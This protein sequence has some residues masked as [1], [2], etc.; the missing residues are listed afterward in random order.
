MA[1]EFE[2]RPVL[3]EETL[4]A[5]D[6]QRDGLYVDCTFGRGGHAARI[7]QALGP[8]GRLLALDKDPHA[9]AVAREQFANE[10]RF[11][12][13]QG[14]FTR[15]EFCVAEQGWLSS[16]DGVLLDLGVSSPQL[17]DA[18]RGFSFRR[19]GELDMRM[20]PSS[21]MSAAQWL[22]TV[23]EQELA[24]VFR[25]YGEE[26]YAKRIARAVVKARETQ[27]ITRTK[28]L[29]EIIAQAHP[30]WEKG[31]DPATRCFQ[32]IRIFINSE[33]DELRT[34]LPQAVNCLKI[35]GRLAV[36]SFHSLEDRIVKRF[37]REQCRGDEFPPG[38]PVTQAMIQPHLRSVGKAIHPGAQEVEENPRARSSVLRVAEKI[39]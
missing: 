7:L 22:K 33:L 13:E 29:A 24:Q 31:K 37:I 14:S 11:M 25:E 21:G 17:D 10:P 6:I 20:D 9:V 36:I 35:G 3:L 34:V 2:H 15:L 4:K 1:S 38:L 23:K 32:A 28:Q 12:I 19:D 30:R 5:L 18:E 39:N 27:P 8:T 16:V 26:R